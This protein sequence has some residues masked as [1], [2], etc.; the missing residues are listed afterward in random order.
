MIAPCLEAQVPGHLSR[1]SSIDVFVM[2][3]SQLSF[4]RGTGHLA[5]ATALEHCA[6]AAF[7]IGA[8]VSAPMHYRGFSVG[9]RLITSIVDKR[10]IVSLLN[11]DARFAFPFGDGYWSLLLDPCYVYEGE[12]DRFLKNV[13][14][15]DYCFIDGGANFGFWSVLASSHPLGSHPVIAIEPSS[16][17][18]KRLSRNAELNNA[19]FKIL[20]RAIGST[21]GDQV[22]L[23]GVKHEAFRISKANGSESGERIETVA[24]NNLL[25]QGLVLPGQKLVIK[26][27][28]EGMEIEAVKGGKRLL[29]N[30]AVIIVEDHGADRTH[31]V[32]RYLLDETQCRLFIFDKASRRY[33]PIIDLSMLDR[34]KTSTA[35]GYNIFATNSLFWEERIRS[36]VLL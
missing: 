33:E 17:N 32:S 27:D 36:I 18:I 35:F 20:H 11:P 8:R 3:D 28:V 6:A 22:W 12:I 14:D 10:E 2:L 9:C 23:S 4:D 25:D 15:V 24:L 26:L 31:A 1:P 5:G 19:R 16:T 34:L 13:A 29:Q 30:E 7:A 21:T